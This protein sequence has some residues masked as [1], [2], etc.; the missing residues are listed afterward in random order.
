[1]SLHGDPRAQLADFGRA[2]AEHA[3]VGVVPSLFDPL[4]LSTSER[5]YNRALGWLL[6]PEADHGAARGV[7]GV[8]A[9][10]L[11]FP[12]LAEDVGAAGPIVVR[13]EAAWP[14]GA[15]ST[16]EPDLLVTTRRTLLLIE[17]KVLAGEGLGQFAD[18]LKALHKLAAARKLIEARAVLCAPEE[19][20]VP[21]GWSA[22]ITH[23]EL[24]GWIVEAARTA[25]MTVWARIGCLMVAEAIAP[26]GRAATL[27]EAAA[28]DAH[29]KARG[30]R[31]R[32]VPRAQDLLDRL[33]DLDC[34]WSEK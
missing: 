2:V 10:R 1:M 31:M 32:D 15:G 14:I 7:L 34:P 27:G 16:R 29:V 21:E 3:R 18:Y 4:G 13:C 23:A 25:P 5:H 24:A 20:D 26:R 12:L 33:G 8:L 30:P 6:N 17:N 11:G 22:S 28:L 19:R 9:E